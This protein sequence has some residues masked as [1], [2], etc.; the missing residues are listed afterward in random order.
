MSLTK[1]I[2]KKNTLLAELSDEQLA[3]IETLSVNDEN[4]V[5]A[6]KTGEIYGNI[7]RDITEVTGLS[8]PEKMRTFDWLKNLLPDVKKVKD[9]KTQIETLSTEKQELEKKLAKGGNV[10][11][12]LKKQIEAKDKKIESM[13]KQFDADKK[14]LEDKSTNLEKRNFDLRMDFESKSAEAHIE[15]IDAIPESTRPLLIKHARTEILSEYDVDS[16]DDGKGGKKT[17][18][19]K[20]GVIANN[21][22]NDLKP[23]TLEDLYKNKLKD[24]LKTG[25]KKQGAGSGAGPTGGG[26]STFDLTGVKTQ[27]D[28]NDAISKHLM[29]KGLARG[30]EEF[31]K[32]FDQ[33]SADNKVNELPMR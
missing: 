1:D 24:N 25:A 27:V 2:L 3:A 30:S 29:D 19:K 7:D 8:K 22:D 12:E 23:Y 11:E 26:S 32:E 5:I 21:P 13:Q 20:D 17:V 10:D 18:F 9:Y 14:L 6:K 28:A 4:D 15:F 31:T 16:I 33:I